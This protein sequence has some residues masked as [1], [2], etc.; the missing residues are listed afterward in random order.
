VVLTLAYRLGLRRSEVVKLST[1]HISFLNGA[2][3]G[4]SVQWWIERGLKTAS[5]SRIIPIKALLSEREMLW[6]ELITAARARG[7]WS[8]ADLLH[9]PIEILKQYIKKCKTHLP[10]SSNNFLF[11]EDSYLG[12]KNK[13]TAQVDKIITLIHEALRAPGGSAG[14][15]RFHHARHSCACNTSLLLLGAHLPNSKKYLFNLMYG[16]PDA[17]KELNALCR[18][19]GFKF[20]VQQS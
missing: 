18:G 15:L 6:L 9:V 12:Q 7:L 17:I 1:A 5:S 8:R 13:S 14:Q 11:I 3:C 20:Q 19:G 16:N 4:L 2:M 10:T